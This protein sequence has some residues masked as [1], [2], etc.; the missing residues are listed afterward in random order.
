MQPGTP[1]PADDP[2]GQGQHGQQPSDPPY[3]GASP[4][5]GPGQPYPSAPPPSQG[6]GAPPQPSSQQNNTLGL[7]GM[8]FGIVGIP[9][10]FCAILG[11]LLG[12]TG[13]VLGSMG[14]KRVSEGRADN[15]GMALAGVICGAIAVVLAIIS[16]AIG[17][18]SVSNS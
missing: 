14:L 6:Y 1:P 17:A 12:A 7:L 10:A 18:I 5:P 11:L 13:I 8:I 4:T 16:G 9:A 15:R 2:Y 3:P